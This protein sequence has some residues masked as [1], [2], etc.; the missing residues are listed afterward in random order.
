MLILPI[1]NRGRVLNVEVKLKGATK[2]H[3]GIRFSDAGESEVIVNGKCF[4]TSNYKDDKSSR[5]ILDFIR[6]NSIRMRR[7]Y[8][9]TTREEASSSTY[10][11]Y[12]VEQPPR[13]VDNGT[14]NL[15]VSLVTD[16]R[17]SIPGHRRGR[18]L[19]FKK[20]GLGE[21]ITDDKIERLEFIVKNVKDSRE[22][23]MLFRREGV[24]D[25]VDMLEF[26]RRLECTVVADSSVNE[27]KLSSIIE[28]L[29]KVNTR[30]SRNLR[31]Y[32][33]MAQ[34]NRDVYS[35]LS[36]VNKL[37]NDKPLDLICSKKQREKQLVKVGTVQGEG[38]VGKAA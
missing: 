12:E 9:V 25:L 32:Y 35:K 8:L 24:A 1:V 18:Y 31:S 15:Y 3:S 26:L 37:V 28:A 2:I 11:V 17:K 14:D 22:W 10:D 38:N 16:L 29:D 30:E 7:N 33:S 19:S 4:S 23:P 21:N 34:D 27:E 5:A 13:R 20:I 6:N 36:I